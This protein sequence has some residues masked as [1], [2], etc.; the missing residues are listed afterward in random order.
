M[1]ILPQLE[2]DLVALAEQAATDTLRTRRP[3]LIRIVSGAVSIAVTLAVALLVLS[4]GHTHRSGQSAPPSARLTREQ[5]AL[6]AVLG[7]MRTPQTPDAAAFDHP[8]WPTPPL[9]HTA[10]DRSLIRLATV[11]PWGAKVYIVA[12]KPPAKRTLARSLGEVA[13]LWV[14][15]N[16][17][18]DYATVN[19]ITAGDVWGPGRAATVHGHSVYRFFEIVPDGVARVI[20]DVLPVMPQ[21][22][23]PPHFTASVAADVHHNVAVFQTNQ[24][25][26]GAVFAS[27]YAHNGQLI[28][29]VGDWKL[30]NPP[31]TPLRH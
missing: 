11:T 17:W 27:W 12:I 1:T 25:G 21:P 29:R 28:K 30:L 20:F 2:R 4:L 24:S 31:K 3:P 16:G 7:V 26:P 22:G 8:G 13:A 5:S 6:V 14:Q 18:S 10:L 19:A 23:K 15:G 9:T